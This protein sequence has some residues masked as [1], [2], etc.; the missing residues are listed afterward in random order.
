MI[1]VAII[2]IGAVVFDPERRLL[3]GPDGRR[4][5]LR[6]KSLDLL[7]VLA[8]RLGETVPKDALVAAVWR[9][10]AVTDDSLTQCVADVRRAIS[11]VDR[12]FLQTVPRQ[13]YRLVPGR[14]MPGGVGDTPAR[15]SPRP[16]VEELAGSAPAGHTPRRLSIV[17]LPFTCRGDAE[18]VAHLADALTD[19]LTTDLSRIS[20]S[21]VIS[22][23]TAATFAAQDRDPRDIVRDVGVRY[24]LEGGLR[25]A[26]A[27][28]HVDAE[29]IDGLTGQSVW[30]DRFEKATTEIHA[31]QAEIT[32]RIA[33]TLNLELK[34]AESRRVGPGDPAAADLALRAWVEVWARPQARACN[35]RALRLAERALELDPDN[36]E[37]LGVAAYA[38][39][40][41]ATYGWGMSR[42]E[43][44]AAGTAAAERALALD[45]RNGDALYAA[46]F[47][48]YL[49][50][51]TAVSL[52]QM[53]QVIAL[54]RNHAPAHFFVGV[55]LVRQGQPGQAIAS[56]D[57]AFLLSPRDPLRSVWHGIVGRARIL[58]EE[59]AEAIATAQKGIAANPSHAHNY[60]VLASAHAHL[61]QAERAR[62]A[63]RDFRDRQPGVTLDAYWRDIASDDPASLTAYRRYIDGLRMAGLPA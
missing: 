57:H 28:L 13:G 24:V 36:A 52:E 26:E 7:A 54:N 48:N 4:I 8:S 55:N 15:A 20:G 40:R 39:A 41:T 18:G 2:E 21:F 32:G 33:R 44:I 50:G 56:I 22:R 47:L 38:H 43:A 37:A 9:D 34:E 17:V 14:S 11:D 23:R 60:S 31:F 53:R 59:D 58:L 35:D 6:P 62:A 1:R 45:P 19:D 10:V 29:L 27:A 30:S 42:A 3:F 25:V 49:A 61:G 5:A 12:M 63:L 16:G 51:R 46:G